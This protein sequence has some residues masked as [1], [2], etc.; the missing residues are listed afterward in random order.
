MR[1]HPALA[2]IAALVAYCPAQD[3]KHPQ[4]PLL[5]DHYEPT[6]A[7]SREH[8]F[9]ASVEGVVLDADGAPAVGATVVV[10]AYRPFY[11]ALPL[12]RARTD[13]QGRYRIDDLSGAGNT[14]LWVMPPATAPLHAEGVPVTMVSGQRTLMRT[15]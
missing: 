13:G 1:L 9:H 5:G 11:W 12:G 15:C 6:S 7:L 14:R 4:P 2:A 10:L 8:Q 3:P